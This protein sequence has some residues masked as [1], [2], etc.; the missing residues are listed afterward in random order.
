MKKT[1]PG[2]IVRLR[3][4]SCVNVKSKYVLETENVNLLM[5]IN[6]KVKYFNIENEN[7][8]RKYL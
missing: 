5:L 8:F 2:F 1:V 3:I 7:N 4:C 6:N